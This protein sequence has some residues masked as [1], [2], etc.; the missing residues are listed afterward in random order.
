MNEMTS[1]RPAVPLSKITQPLDVLIVGAGISGLAAARYLK[2][3]RPDDSFAIV[4]EKLTFGGTWVTHTY[5][6]IRSDSDLHTFGFSFKP[7]V[8]P[9]I[10]TAAEILAYLDETI[11]EYGLADH[12][13]YGWRGQTA[14]WDSERKLWTLK[15]QNVETGEM[16]EISARFLWMCQGYYRHSEGYTPQWPGMETFKGEVIHPQTWP[17]DFD[18]KGKHLVV[19]GS[20]ATAA[21]LVPNVVDQVEHV[22]MLQRSPT[23]FRSEKNEIPIAKRLRELQVE[24]DWVHEIVRR[25]MLLG[26]HDFTNR[27]FNEPETVRDELIGIARRYLGEEFDVEKHFTPSYL[28]W[29]QRIA[30]IPDG[31]LYKALATGRASVV[32]D[33]IETFVEDGIKL[34]SGEFLKADVVATAT[35]FNLCQM[36]D[37]RFDIDGEALD[38]HDTLGY[39]SMMFTGVPNL[40]WVMGY[41]RSSWTLRAELVAQ[42]VVRLLDHMQEHQK[43]TVVPRLRESEKDMQIVDWPDE[44]DFNPGYLLRGKNVLPKRGTTNEWRLNQDYWT[45]KDDFAAIDFGDE[46]FAYD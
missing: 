26:S 9:P 39:R 41:W 30:R 22:T 44:E 25:E 40:A 27:C 28:P 42:F 43:S 4:D 37:I 11:D 36:G 16:E 2:V 29:R 15:V 18:G 23:Y 21:T 35:G 20:G 17:E 8:G 38:F 7:W 1:V 6:G 34:K 45:E 5:P 31:D 32:T 19:I 3:E 46:V 13:H 24:E 33:E 12:I 10:A 14:S